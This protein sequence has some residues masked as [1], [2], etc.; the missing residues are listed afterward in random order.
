MVDK[1]NTNV[2]IGENA[3]VN[4]NDGKVDDMSRVAAAISAAGGASAGIQIAK[5]VGGPPAVKI[6]AGVATAAGVQATTIIMKNILSSNS[7]NND[8]S[9]KL[10]YNLIALSNDS[11]MLNEY[12]LNL[13]VH[14]NT[15]LICVMVFLYIIL[16]IYLSKYLIKKDFVK[17][18]PQSNKIGKFFVFWLNKY[19]NLWSKS[20]N[21]LLGYCYFMI[22][23]FIAVC[24]FVLFIILSY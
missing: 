3:T 6:A 15:L 21:Y 22:F 8:Y 4:I 18:I 20:S 16:N 24:K 12:P 11:N 23:F 19:L 10:V 5:Y 2:N 9:K 7:S 13:L 1:D 17:Y 14:V